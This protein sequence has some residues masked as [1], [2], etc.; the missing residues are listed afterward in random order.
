VRW[1]ICDPKCVCLQGCCGGLIRIVS[2]CEVHCES[3]QRKAPLLLVELLVQPGD[4]GF[5]YST[6]LGSIQAKL[7]EIFDRA[8]TRLQASPCC[9]TACV[10]LLHVLRVACGTLDAHCTSLSTA[11]HAN[12]ML[13][14]FRH[15]SITS[16]QGL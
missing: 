3:E 10:P 2:P 1:I 4:A 6:P 13:D 5:A 9:A 12:H 16:R 7:V 15:W 14:S 8:L 11:L